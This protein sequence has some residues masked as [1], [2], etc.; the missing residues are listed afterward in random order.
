MP[1]GSYAWEQQIPI[2]QHFSKCGFKPHFILLTPNEHSFI[3]RID[4]AGF[5]W[6]S[7]EPLNPKNTHQMS[8]RPH[9]PR[10]FR[11]KLY[12]TILGLPIGR[13]ARAFFSILFETAWALVQ[14][15]SLCLHLRRKQ[16]RARLILRNM[17]LRCSF[18]SQERVVEFLPLLKV[19]RDLKV[20]IILTPAADSSPDGSALLRRKDP[21]HSAGL[22]KNTELNDHKRG[23]YSGVALLNAI[24]AH[25][26]P[27]QVYQSPWGKMLFTSPA[28][29]IALK[30]MAM[31]PRNLWY[32]GTT[33]ADYIVIS[34][35]DEERLC[36]EAGIDPKKL[37]LFGSHEL[38]VLHELSDKKTAI[39]RRLIATQSKKLTIVSPPPM[40]EHGLEPP[41]THWKIIDDLLSRVSEASEYVFVS[42]HPKESRDDYA[43]VEKKYD[44]RLAPDALKEILP[45]ADYF[46]GTYSSTLRWAAALGIPSINADLW[47]YN[48]E[49]FSNLEGLTKVT[50]GDQLTS[51][52]RQSPPKVDLKPMRSNRQCPLGRNG[53]VIDGKAK[54]RLAD[55]ISNLPA[56]KPRPLNN[57]GNR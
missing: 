34:G 40:L 32:Q 5:T 39:K 45:A 19:L 13:P 21:L 24:T 7:L 42:L 30:I 56:T 46:V 3:D 8:Q 22:T 6:D 35:R 55:F 26:M 43:W 31:L 36:L 9:S 49:M 47:G 37:L 16:L 48:L 10:S 17:P 15:V 50:E 25:R 2:A 28:R 41:T 51:A 18:V 11:G 33:F 4:S 38:D 27:T 12:R 54:E 53:I 57:P 14:I 52:L 1:L 29:L 44:V 20:P 23:S